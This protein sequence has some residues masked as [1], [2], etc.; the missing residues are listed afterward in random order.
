MAS[1]ILPHDYKLFSSSLI[2]LFIV[3]RLSVMLDVYPAVE[4]Y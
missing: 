4:L 1:V 3:V 2:F